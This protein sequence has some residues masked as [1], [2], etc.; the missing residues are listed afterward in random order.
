MKT[1][2]AQLEHRAAVH[3]EAIRIHA[4]RDEPQDDHA[5]VQRLRAEL[6]H[7]TDMVD[8]L[9]SGEA[10]PKRGR[11]KDDREA[12]EAWHEDAGR[13]IHRAREALEQTAHFSDT[14]SGRAK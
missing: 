6:R 9:L 2:K 12:H 7:M 14:A 8:A 3:H 5:A 11:T 4:P 13:A 10:P 1:T